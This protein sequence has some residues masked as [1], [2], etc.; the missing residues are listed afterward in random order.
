MSDIQNLLEEF[1]KASDYY[2]ET[3]RT[4]ARVHL[5]HQQGNASREDDAVADNARR[6]A[7]E[8]MQRLEQLVAMSSLEILS[9]ESREVSPDIKPYDSDEIAHEL[10]HD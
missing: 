4:W 10:G 3:M 2:A 7:F 1:I 6:H 5:D 8:E 9:E